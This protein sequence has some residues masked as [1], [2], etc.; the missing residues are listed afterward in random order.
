MKKATTIGTLAELLMP[1]DS[2]EILMIGWK[3]GMNVLIALSTVV[4]VNRA[5]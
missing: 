4:D 5:V 3:Y 2:L 1:C